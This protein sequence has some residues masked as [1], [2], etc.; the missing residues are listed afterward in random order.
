MEVEREGEVILGFVLVALGECCGE[1]RL[2][3]VLE[4]RMMRG[5]V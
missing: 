2:V 1:V 5:A 3:L 4:D